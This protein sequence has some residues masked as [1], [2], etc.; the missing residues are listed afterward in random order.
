M[1]D[2]EEIE[3]DLKESQQNLDD[4]DAEVCFHQEKARGY[5]R[6]VDRFAKELIDAKLILL[7]EGK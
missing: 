6:D 3:D 2:I 5:Q 4:E 7:S 1:R